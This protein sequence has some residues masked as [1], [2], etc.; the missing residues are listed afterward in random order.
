M[1]CTIIDLKESEGLSHHPLQPNLNLR[2]P[3]P[4]PLPHPPNPLPILLKPSPKPHLNLL[5]PLP[6][7]KAIKIVLHRVLRLPVRQLLLLALRLFDAR[8]ADAP[9]T[10]YG[11]EALGVGD[12]AGCAA[13]AGAQ[14]FEVCVLGEVGC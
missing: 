7:L 5:P 4:P 11:Y 12:G 3:N 9:P 2:P 1:R 10:T 8:G 14:G 13:V 6:I